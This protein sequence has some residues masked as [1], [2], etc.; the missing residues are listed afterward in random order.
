MSLL[1]EFLEVIP[2]ILSS[3][4]EAVLVPVQGVDH[5]QDL[6]REVLTIAPAF[7]AIAHIVMP[8]LQLAIRTVNLLLAK[9][10]LRASVSIGRLRHTLRLKVQLLLAQS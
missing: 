6:E 1:R 3:T 4:R 7:V 10:P 5:V 2:E 8:I 9:N